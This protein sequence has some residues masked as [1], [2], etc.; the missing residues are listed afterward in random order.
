M[1]LKETVTTLDH[2]RGSL[3]APVV[4]VEYGDFECPYCA[5]SFVTLENLIDD[6]K[7]DLCFIYRHFPL[8]PA[9]PHAE[10][11]ALAAEAAGRQ[12]KFW[13]MHHLLFRNFDQLSA[14]NIFELAQMAKLNLE[15]FQK[16]FADPL[17]MQKVRGDVVT[18]TQTGVDGT[19]ALFFNGFRYHGPRTYQALRVLVT[20]LSKGAENAQFPREL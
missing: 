20:S 17:L 9:H 1:N 16:D 11:A 4:L 8:A 14:E 2:I 19:P 3:D 12:D 13:E 15:Q 7:D 6:C 5:E 18:G 10:I